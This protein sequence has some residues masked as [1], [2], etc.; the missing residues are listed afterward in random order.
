[1]L[2]QF[3]TFILVL[4]F[5]LSLFGQQNDPV[6]FTV[7]QKPIHLSEFKYIY[8]KTNGDK[9]DFSKQS[10]E[11]YLDLYVKFKLKVQ[12]AKELKLDT[13]P[14]L[15][16]ELA[17]YR[18]Q[19]A[20]SY[21]V[22]K[23]VTEKLVKEAYDRTLQDVDISHI[24]ISLAQD[25]NEEKTALAKKKITDIKN[26]LDKTGLFEGLAKK[27]SEDTYTKDRDGRLGYFTALFR[28]GFY[29]M[30]TAAYNLEVGK[31]SD[32]VRTAAGF[33]IIKLNNIRPARGE[34]EV[35][36]ILIR[37]GKDKTDPKAKQQ[38]DS[39]YQ[40]LKKGGNF[41]ELAK[42]HSQHAQSGNKGGYVGF[43]STNSPVEEAFKDAAFSL[44]TDGSYTKPIESSVGWHI[45]RRISKKVDEPY[46]VVKR[47]LQTKIQNN[48]RGKAKM[49]SRQQLAKDAM[50]ERIKKESNFQEAHMVVQ[51]FLASLD[52]SFVTHRWKKPADNKQAMFT[53]GTSNKMDFTIADFGNFCK[54]SARRLRMGKKANP[55]DVATLIYGDYVNDSALKFEESQLEA[56]YPEFKSLMREY[57]EGILLFEATKI[58]VWDKASQDS[59]GLVAFHK[60]QTN[61][62]QWGDRAVVDVYT[63]RAGNEGQLA[64]IR[65]FA[66]NNT[67]EQVLAKFNT[68]EKQHLAVQEKTY[69]KG[70]NE[71]IDAMPWRVGS[72]SKTTVNDRNKASSFMIIRAIKPPGEKTL[73]EA[74]GYVIA[75]YQDFLEKQWLK[76]LKDRYKVDIDRKV[77]ESLIK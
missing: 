1:M 69:E 47:R 35:G 54:R 75:D 12:K 38:I 50:I 23:E 15:Q 32:P 59:T 53:F 70:K 56:K 28:E 58:L 19:L 9:A 73:D 25:A 39:L 52:S 57:E 41:E 31:Y 8:N 11:E 29:E 61:K 43:T 63:L 77:F 76:E 60:T 55:Q 48:A 7:E 30:E 6:L 64:E 10:L 49:F 45:I 40:V 66:I 72:I 20:N 42:K 24:M 14:S 18:R 34:V 62:Y 3:I 5:G 67:A 26:M 37:H 33:H 27:F 44:D 4:T 13:I 74:R 22:D 65:K 46:E 17:G 36:H 51:S 16:T 2:K 68:G 71:I 21:L